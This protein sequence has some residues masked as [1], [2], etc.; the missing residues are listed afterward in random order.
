MSAN[1]MHG[2][3]LPSSSPRTVAAFIGENENGILRSFSQALHDSIAPFGFTGEIINVNEEG[4]QSQLEKLIANGLLLAWGPAGIGAHLELGNVSFWDNFQ[5]PFVSVLSDSPSQ[6]PRNHLVKSRFVGNAYMIADWLEMQ[7]R[8]VHAPQ[9][10]TVLPQSIM[11]NP[12]RDLVA[13]SDR[14]YRMVF[15]KTGQAPE[16]H[17]QSWANWPARFRAIIEDCVAEALR[18]GVGDIS[19]PFLASAD[20]HGLM[21]DGRVDVLFGL[22]YA[23]DIYIR[24]IRSMA[25]VK[26]LIDLPVDI[27]GRGWDH[28]KTGSQKARFHA[29]INA[30]TL[31]LLFA[32]TQ[33][34]LNTMPN[35]SSGTHERV[36]YGFAARSCVITNENAEMR[37]RFGSLPSFFA[38]STE[39]EELA[40]QLAALHATSER[41]DDKTQP[42]L[43]LVEQEFSPVGFM[44]ALIEFSLEIR[45][46][47]AFS[48]FLPS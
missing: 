47:A 28:L 17:R 10:G 3:E 23:A 12:R 2:L 45:A 27:I 38:V 14:E 15:V 31:P 24:D 34:L 16:L 32:N 46:A 5:V 6:L 39:A 21:L 22:L 42:A 8:W 13:W 26:A 30:D 25:M 9:L 1:L 33:F 43:D 35:F 29:A 40:D 36:L 20:H 4:W 18:Q 11:E 48:P 44:R 41:Y 7:Q 37:R 19:K